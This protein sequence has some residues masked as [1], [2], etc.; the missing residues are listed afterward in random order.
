MA[1]ALG[2]IGVI[3]ILYGGGQIPTGNYIIAEIAKQLLKLE[4]ELYGVH[5]SF[6]GLGDENC[7]E[8]FS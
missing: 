8:R 3:A 5:K 4:C 7:Y 1:Y 2:I 6:L